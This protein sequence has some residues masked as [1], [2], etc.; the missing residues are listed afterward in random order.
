MFIRSV[1]LI[2]TLQFPITSPTTTD[3]VTKILRRFIIQEAQSCHCLPTTCSLQCQERKMAT[4]HG[5]GFE[6]NA[7][8][9]SIS[10]RIVQI[11]QWQVYR[12]Q[13]QILRE[14][15]GELLRTSRRLIDPQ[16]NRLHDLFSHLLAGN[17]HRKEFPVTFGVHVSAVQ[18]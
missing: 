11:R 18:R 16:C 10:F 15:A 14:A 4:D 9:S 1:H 6:C 12:C 2:F 5:S 8:E 3:E 7:G 13:Q 17:C